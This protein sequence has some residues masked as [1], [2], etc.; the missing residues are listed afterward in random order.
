MTKAP[1]TRRTARK[2]AEDA[3]EAS[4]QTRTFHTSAAAEWLGDPVP[5]RSALDRIRAGIV[6]PP[7][8]MDGRALR[9][10]PKITLATGPL[11]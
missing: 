6:E 9:Y 4:K 8:Y 1:R 5:G 10:Q 3:L 11:R 2:I 7:P